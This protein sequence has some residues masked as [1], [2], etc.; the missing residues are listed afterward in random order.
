MDKTITITFGEIAENH[1]G[2]EKIGKEIAEGLNL[3]DLQHVQRIF[4]GY[5]AD[6]SIYRLNDLL[7][8]NVPNDIE[9]AYFCIVKNGVNVLLSHSQNNIYTADDVYKEQN[10]L[11]PDTKAKMRG[12]EVNKLARHNLCFSNFDQEAD[13]KN[14]KGTV[15]SWDKIPLTNHIRKCIG[16][17]VGEKANDLEGEG[18]YYYD[19]KKCGIG[20]HGDG[21]RKIVIAMRLGATFP[22][23]YQW[24]HQSKPVG[25]RFVINVEHGDIYFMSFKATGNDWKKRSKYT[26]RHAAGAKKYTTIVDKKKK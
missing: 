17:V 23:H 22:L 15:V 8:D 6:V 12:R 2:M 20:F 1:A 25:K 7:P 18:N 11:T 16:I 10:S 13:I 14:G 24:F 3:A 5:G 9:D 21:E 4:M 19:L 26:L